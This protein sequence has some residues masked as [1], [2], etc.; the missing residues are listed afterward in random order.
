MSYIRLE[1]LP[2]ENI[3]L[4]PEEKMLEESLVFRGRVVFLAFSL[5]YLIIG[6]PGN[7]LTLCVLRRPSFKNNDIAFYITIMSYLNLLDIV[8]FMCLPFTGSVTGTVVENINS[9]LCMLSYLSFMAVLS[10]NSWLLTPMTLAKIMSRKN[11]AVQSNTQ[12]LA[13][14]ITIVFMLCAVN[15]GLLG[16]S[17]VGYQEESDNKFVGC[18]QTRNILILTLEVLFV[19]IMPLAVMF[20]L[21]IYFFFKPHIEPPSEAMFQRR[22]SSRAGSRRPSMMRRNSRRKSSVCKEV[23]KTSP[24]LQHFVLLLDLQYAAAVLPTS[25]YYFLL[26][27]HESST[28]IDEA[29][30]KFALSLSMVILHMQVATSFILFYTCDVEFRKEVRSTWQTYLLGK[31]ETPEETPVCVEEIQVVRNDTDTHDIPEPEATMPH[32]DNMSGVR[33]PQSMDRSVT[34]SLN[35]NQ[36]PQI[37][38]H[39]KHRG[40][41]IN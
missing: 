32:E 9:S 4:G 31:G 19:S 12:H 11:K 41:E 34:S 13:I 39:I 17:R 38:E 14:S 21:Y 23:Q 37:L 20:V 10:I 3:T 8:F 1:P 2:H 35:Q 36:S 5:L 6:F 22:K 18:Y 16:I 33:T 24:A 25:T 29:K 28:I 30:E 26:F 27:S 40:S 15:S 7:L